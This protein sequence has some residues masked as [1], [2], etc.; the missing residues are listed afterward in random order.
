MIKNRKD[1]KDAKE[2]EERVTEIIPIQT[3]TILVVHCVNFARLKEW[4]HLAPW[5]KISCVHK[6]A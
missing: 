6:S 5:L 1:A 2:E 4:E 3:E